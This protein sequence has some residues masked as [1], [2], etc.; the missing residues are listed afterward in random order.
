[1]YIDDHII[2]HNYDLSGRKLQAVYLSKM[3]DIG[4][5]I[6]IDWS[7]T[8]NYDRPIIIDTLPHIR[9]TS[10]MSSSLMSSVALPDYYQELINYRF[11]DTLSYC[12]PF[13]YRNS[14]LVQ[15][16]YDGGCVTMTDNT[17]QFR[18]YQCDH[19]GSVRAVV[20][21]NGE[22]LQRNA[23][24]PFGGLYQAD[25]TDDTYRYK[26]NG[27]ELDRTFGHNMYDYGARWQDPYLVRFTTIDPLAEK[28]YHL[29]P[30]AYCANNPVNAVDPDGRR[31]VFVNGF[32]GFG[33][34]AGGEAYWNGRHSL[35]VKGA[36]ATFDDYATP[37]FVKYDYNY[38][39]SSSY[40]RETQGYRY[41][42]KNY[43]DLT[44]GMKFGTDKFNFV[45]HSMGGAFSEGMIR[46][47]SEQ[48]WE[49]DNAVFL[50]AW[51]PLRISNKE[52]KRRI[53]A[54]LTNDLV[55]RLSIPLFGNPDIPLSD[56]KVR[57]K[58]DESVLHVHRDFIDS[59]NDFWNIITKFLQK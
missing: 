14:K 2:Y 6:D 36:H 15:A 19:L 41:A 32:L 46:Y 13:I 42:E 39:E 22:V 34:P 1:M 25:A 18:F 11:R 56:V 45:S 40:L 51:E 24:Y 27:K 59:G 17:P 20:K 29:S 50:N 23:Y 5:D 3:P 58:S 33:S 37:Y 16:L 10:L 28:Y 55:Q 52:E 48:G 35:F 38:L 47:L 44:E 8:I 4:V 21:T 53:D 49:T 30:Y 54:T 12:G 31:I 26:Y 43:D 57:I 7:D 9:P